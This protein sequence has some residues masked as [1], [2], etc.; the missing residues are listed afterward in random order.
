VEFKEA[1]G[2]RRTI[3]YFQPY[4]PVEKEKVQKILEAARLQCM[5]GNAQ[6]ARRAVVVTK[7]ETPDDVRD[8]LIDAL[9]NQPQAAQAPVAIVWVQD[10]DG[11]SSF[12]DNMVELLRAQVLTASYGWSEE[13]IDSTIARTGDFNVLAG[14]PTFAEWV[15]A[16]ECGL[17]VGAAVLAAV[18]EGLGT[19]LITGR[20]DEIRKLFGMPDSCTP[21]QVQLVGYA[22]ESI[23][24]GGQRPRPDFSKLYFEHTWGNPMPRDPK[25]V[26]ELEAARMITAAA[27]HP[28]RKAEL[29]ALAGMFGLPE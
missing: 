15:T 27:L 26:A 14:D 21:T 18:D 9:Y 6:L 19:G 16:F 13:F 12:R 24:G 5:H 11:W 10:M 1:V 22:A 20:R 17:A 23:D 3:R 29:R 8:E 25:V 2:L 4:R 7:G 28:W